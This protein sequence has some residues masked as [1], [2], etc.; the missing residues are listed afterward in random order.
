MEIFVVYPQVT[1]A[2]DGDAGRVCEGFYV[3]EDGVVTMTNPDGVPV[4]DA[5]GKRVEHKLAKG[6]TAQKIAGRLT[7]KIY[8]SRQDES[9]DFNRPL[10]N[11]SY[12]FRV[13]Y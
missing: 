11:R 5:D 1:A 3:V 13:P 12:Q 6:E 2:S 8:F 9:G 4:R 10:T 7:L